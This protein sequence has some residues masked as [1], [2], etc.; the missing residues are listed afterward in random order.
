VGVRYL[1]VVRH[2]Q[3]T[4]AAKG[5]SDFERQLSK[6]GRRQCKQL[7]EWA[8][9]PNELGR[10][11]PTT[12]LVSSAERTRE[13]FRRA[14][15][16]TPFAGPREFSELIYNGRREVTAEDLLIE[17]AAV[18]PVTRSLLVIGH[19]PTVYELLLSLLSEPPERLRTKG[20]PLGGAFV[21]AIPDNRQIGLARYE[22][23]A[24]YVPD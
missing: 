14:F 21:L 5:A 10:F 15:D 1:T 3:S 19:N 23:V 8:L 17:L 20:Y 16:D 24:S 4:P 13:T 22:L 2:C 6:R 7:R 11:G 18:D 9:D 12:A